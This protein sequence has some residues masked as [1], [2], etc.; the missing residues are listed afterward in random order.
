[1]EAAASSRTIV[2]ERHRDGSALLI[3]PETTAKEQASA[4]E[5]LVG[6]MSEKAPQ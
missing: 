5:L 1:M 4:A 2:C 6:A 3:V